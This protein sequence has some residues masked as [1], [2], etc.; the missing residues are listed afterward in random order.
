M[1]RTRIDTGT[2]IDFSSLNLESDSFFSVGSAS[3]LI[4]LSTDLFIFR[5]QQAGRENKG[6]QRYRTGGPSGALAVGLCSLSHWVWS[7]PYQ[8]WIPFTLCSRPMF[9]QRFPQFVLFTWAAFNIS[10]TVKPISTTSIQSLSLNPS[11]NRV[12]VSSFIHHN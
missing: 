5:A 1:T 12:C 2:S 4:F 11:S 8:H 6:L 3:G 9:K 10:S 7:I